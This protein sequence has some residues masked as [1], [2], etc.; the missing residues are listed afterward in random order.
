MAGFAA[1]IKDTFNCTLITN[2]KKLS[3]VSGNEV[4]QNNPQA[5][6]SEVYFHV[7]SLQHTKMKTFFSILYIQVLERQNRSRM[8]V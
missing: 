5:Y 3:S 8:Y 1:F 4:P 7:F 2:S 6:Y